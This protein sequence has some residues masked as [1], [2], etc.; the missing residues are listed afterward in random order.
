MVLV[1][2]ICQRLLSAQTALL[3]SKR[4][5]S[6]GVPADHASGTQHP[7]WADAPRGEA[8]LSNVEQ[9]PVFEAHRAQ[10]SEGEPKPSPSP[11][12]E[13]PL[14][15]NLVST[16]LDGNPYRVAWYAHSGVSPAKQFVYWGFRR[17]RELP[18]EW[19]EYYRRMLRQEVK[20]SAIVIRTWDVFMMIVDGYRKGKWVL[21]KYGIPIDESIIPKPYNNFWQETTHD[22]RVWAY[23]RS[24]QLK[25]LQALQR[26]ADSLVFGA[27]TVNRNDYVV[28]MITNVSSGMQGGTPVHS[29]DLPAPTENE[30]RA[31]RHSEEMSS[32]LM[33][34]VED[35]K[36][37]NPVLRNRLATQKQS[38]ADELLGFEDDDDV[39]A[40]LGEN[41]PPSQWPRGA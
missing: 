16:T 38:S 24:H 28:N 4:R 27:Q 13:E 11:L 18:P 3:L 31:S 35:D 32:A 15:A 40:G 22:E 30:I 6:G 7:L 33:S 41:Q 10:N 17:L 26:D 25:E 9:T 36:L 5:T 23:R 21:E 29:D 2:R 39:P 34:A 19:Q 12:D 14:A 1:R 8:V 20:A 37:W